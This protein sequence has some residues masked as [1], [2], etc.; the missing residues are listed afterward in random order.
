MNIAI[1]LAGGVGSRT[2]FK[3]PK[4]FIDIC[5]KPLIIYT[6]ENFENQEEID[7][8]AIVCKEGWKEELTSYLQQYGI[9]KVKWIIEGGDTR[10]ESVYNAIMF[11]KDKCK[12]EDIVLIHD[13]ARLFLSKE[14][15]KNNIYGAKKHGAVNTVIPCTDTIVESLNKETISSV[16]NRNNLYAAQTPQSFKYDLIFEAHRKAMESEIKDCSDD[17]QLILKMGKDVQLVEGN[18]K[19]FKVTTLE[20]FELAEALIT[21]NKNEYCKK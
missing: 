15:I 14:I 16:P 11:L 9:D 8:I 5:G 21:I 10:Q 2:G 13:G 4:Q 12:G 19:N 1:V 3:R 6:I 17:C 7:A 18:K 20:D